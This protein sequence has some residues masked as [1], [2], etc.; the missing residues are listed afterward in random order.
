MASPR[1]YTTEEIDTALLTYWL[2]GQSPT[3]AAELLGIPKQTIHEWVTQHPRRL[4]ELRQQNEAAFDKTIALR[5]EGIQIQ[6]LDTIASLLALT[7]I[8][9]QAGE[10]KNP[11]QAA[12]RISTVLGIITD[13]WLL[14]KGRPNSIVGT[15]DASEHLKALKARFPWL[16]TDST[17]E[18]ITTTPELPEQSEDT[19]L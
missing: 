9:I 12:Q 14:I 1:R 5:A 2:E 18:D 6:A 10:M 7:D 8:K 13:K 17:A 4:E 11:D 19:A 16:V 3:R 15:S